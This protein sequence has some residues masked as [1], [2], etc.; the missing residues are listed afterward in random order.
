MRQTK[1]S[2]VGDNIRRLREI[3]GLSSKALARLADLSSIRMIESGH[4]PGRVDTL[5]KIAK[6]LGVTVADL[7]ADVGSGHAAKRQR[8]VVR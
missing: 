4:R 3:A 6:A 7:F 1:R 5:E 8:R 2:I